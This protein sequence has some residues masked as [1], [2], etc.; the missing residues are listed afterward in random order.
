MKPKPKRLS[1]RYYEDEVEDIL[2]YDKVKDPIKLSITRIQNLY[3]YII[4]HHSQDVLS[5]SMLEDFNKLK[6]KNKKEKRKSNEILLI[7]VL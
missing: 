7:K 2:S 5:I 6:T 3:L 4:Y 1:R